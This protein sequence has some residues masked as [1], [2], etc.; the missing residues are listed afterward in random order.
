MKCPYA[1]V[2]CEYLDIPAGSKPIQCQTC[3]HYKEPE[4]D[5][6]RTTSAA[7]VLDWIIDKIKSFRNDKS[8][9]TG[10]S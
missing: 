7:P 10:P 9:P 8:T 4:P 2:C 3:E 1:D 6:V 5:R